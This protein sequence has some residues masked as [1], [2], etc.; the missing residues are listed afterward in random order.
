MK[1]QG[2]KKASLLLAM[3]ML[4]TLLSVQGLAETADKTVDYVNPRG[5]LTVYSDIK[6]RKAT[7]RVIATM[8]DFTVLSLLDGWAE[9]EGHNELGEPFTGYIKADKLRE[10]AQSEGTSTFVITSDARATLQKTRSKTSQIIGKY[11]PGVRVQVL[12]MAQ[13]GFVKVRIGAVSGYLPEA[14][15]TPLTADMKATEIAESKVDYA[16][17][18]GI[19]LRQEPSYK[20]K[21]LAVVSNGKPVRVLGVGQEFAHVLTENNQTGFIM[22]AGL[23]P[24]ALFSDKAVATVEK[25]IPMPEGPL[26]AVNNP[27]GQGAT[28]RSRKSTNSDSLGL[29]LNGSRVVMLKWDKYW[30]RVWVDGREGYM[31]TRMLDVEQYTPPVDDSSVIVGPIPELPPLPG[32]STGP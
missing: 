1:T 4:L 17:G 13:K 28:L 24:Q 10:R 21:T 32:E 16:K 25:D 26:V 18:H 27:E 22:A 5:A 2:V 9:I 29:Y 15:V 7:G 3:M 30:V 12:E 19:N 14:A 8:E 11:F 6:S 31:M 20:A 23:N